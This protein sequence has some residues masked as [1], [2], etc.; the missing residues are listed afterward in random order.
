M[1]PLLLLCLVPS[2]LLAG[3]MRPAPMEQS[4]RPDATAPA[5]GPPAEPPTEA[6]AVPSPGAD[7][8]G[9]SDVPS[10]AAQAGVCAS[11]ADCG[12]TLIREGECCPMLC[13]PRGVTAKEA[14][15]LE[16]KSQECEQRQPCAVPMCAPPRAQPVPVCE[17]GRC[18][19]RHVNRETR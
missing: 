12:L 1:R 11:D 17:A 6:Q 13:A 7:A 16:R 5:A 10:E 19:V 14:Q 4:T 2:L 18:A 15:A 3:C 9:G 8:R